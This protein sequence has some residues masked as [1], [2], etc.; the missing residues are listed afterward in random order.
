LKKRGVKVKHTCERTRS[1]I[2]TFM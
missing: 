1:K 2:C